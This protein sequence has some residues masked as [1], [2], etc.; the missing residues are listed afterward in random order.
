MAEKRLTINLDRATHQAA[1]VK[2]A[3]EGR[4]LSD[5]VREWLKTWLANDQPKAEVKT[6]T[7]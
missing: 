4:T 1:R 2:A 5:I 6:P 3:Q 7:R